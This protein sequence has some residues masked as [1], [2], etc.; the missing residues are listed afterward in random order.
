MTAG[1]VD[2]ARNHAFAAGG[3]HPSLARLCVEGHAKR[4]DGVPRPSN[5]GW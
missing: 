1:E 5:R 2:R 3:V 4:V